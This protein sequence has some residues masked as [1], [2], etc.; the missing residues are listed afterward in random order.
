MV[1]AR[2]R[3]STAGRRRGQRQ[4]HAH[5]GKRCACFSA[6]TMDGCINSALRHIG[7][8]AQVDSAGGGH[9]TNRRDLAR[10]SAVRGQ[11]HPI[12]LRA[13]ERGARSRPRYSPSRL[14][15]MHF[16]SAADFVCATQECSTAATT[17]MQAS[18]GSGGP[19]CAACACIHV[20]PATGA[21]R[22]VR[23]TS[24]SMP[25]VAGPRKRG[26]DEAAH[27]LLDGDGE[28]HQEG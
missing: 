12:L 14:A 20:A 7:A 5:A 8:G 27:K 28:A 19:P 4:W 23:S 11:Q 21:W 18:P 17:C 6:L 3:L 2:I 22:S 26:P 15:A 24:D 10:A 9:L 1:Q 13:L 16:A 25:L